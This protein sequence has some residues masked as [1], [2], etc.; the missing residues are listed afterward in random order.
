MESFKPN[1]ISLSLVTK[2]VLLN[3]LITKGILS[4]G[5]LIEIT[6][7]DRVIK[8]GS[9]ASGYVPY[10]K[11]YWKRFQRDLKEGEEIKHIEVF[12]K[13]NLKKK[14]WDIT[15]NLI[16]QH[17]KAELIKYKVIEESA[18]LDIRVTYLDPV[19]EKEKK[20]IV[21]AEKLNNNK[22]EEKSDIKAQRINESKK[23]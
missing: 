7:T 10:D 12:L 3:G 20:P 2:G 15:V 1:H 4:Q 18:P 5:E 23:H 6:T 8:T 22:K 21:L 19:K 13:R 17:I 14:E 9:G 16:Q 11:D